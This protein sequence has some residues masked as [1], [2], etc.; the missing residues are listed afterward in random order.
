MS[1]PSLQTGPVLPVHDDPMWD[2][3]ALYVVAVVLRVAEQVQAV[4]RP[5][6][7]YLQDSEHNMVRRSGQENKDPK[8]TFSIWGLF[9]PHKW[10][11]GASLTSSYLLLFKK[12]K[13]Q[14]LLQLTKFVKNLPILLLIIMS[15]SSPTEVGDY[16]VFKCK[17]KKEKKSIIIKNHKSN[18]F[19]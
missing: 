19:K 17:K 1:R 11:F 7:F 18:I 8:Q 6:I 2:V 14:S 13:I 10:N 4:A 15:Y 12:V 3:N 5:L 9:A 16:A